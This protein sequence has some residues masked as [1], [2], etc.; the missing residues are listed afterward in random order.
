MCN[1]HMQQQFIYLLIWEGG[2]W[3][4]LEGEYIGE[5]EG[6]KGEWCNSTFKIILKLKKEYVQLSDKIKESLNKV[7][8]YFQIKKKVWQLLQPWQ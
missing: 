7:L 1:T 3:E 6:K 4:K 2:T 5:A 8:L